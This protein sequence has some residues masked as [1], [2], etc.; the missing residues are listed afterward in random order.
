MS[1]KSEPWTTEE[2]NSSPANYNCEILLSDVNKND[3]KLN[4]LPSDS[5]I[6]EYSDAEGNHIDIC[7]SSK[8]ASIFDLYYDKFGDHIYRI[9][10]SNGRISPRNW[11]RS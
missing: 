4:E 2:L 7:R 6:V 8:M 1:N 10:H 9:E 11:K 5:H 3:I